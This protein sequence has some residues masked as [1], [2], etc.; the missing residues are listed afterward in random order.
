MISSLRANKIRLIALEIFCRNSVRGC[1]RA[2][3]EEEEPQMLEN[4]DLTSVLIKQIQLKIR[5]C[6]VCTKWMKEMTNR[7][8]R[9]DKGEI[10][11]FSGWICFAEQSILLF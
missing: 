9:Y 6:S 8:K 1:S 5:M 10:N 11:I 4:E 7:L 2:S 3:T